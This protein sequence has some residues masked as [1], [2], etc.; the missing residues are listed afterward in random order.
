MIDELET[1]L[2]DLFSP[3]RPGGGR[4]LFCLTNNRALKCF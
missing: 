3:I 2:L 1:E 4:H